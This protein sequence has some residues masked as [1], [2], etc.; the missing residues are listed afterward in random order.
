MKMTVEMAFFGSGTQTSGTDNF[1][2]S[3]PVATTRYVD[4]G[5]ERGIAPPEHEKVIGP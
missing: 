4:V 5:V 3:R 2:A 1:I